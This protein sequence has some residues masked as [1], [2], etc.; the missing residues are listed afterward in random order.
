V[1]EL[2]LGTGEA[3]DVLAAV[4]ARVGLD[5]GVDLLLIKGASL[6]AHGLREDRGRGDV[7]VLVRPKHVGP[8]RRVLTTLGWSAFNEPSVY[9]LIVPPHA[10]TFVHPRWH[11]EID[12][13]TF[14][15]GCYADPTTCFEHL[16]AERTTIQLAHQPVECTGPAGSALI[17]GLTLMRTPTRPRMT[18]ESSQWRAAVSAWP[19]PERM[20]L[21]RLAADCQSADALAPLFDAAGVPPVGRGANTTANWTDWNDRV[22]QE[23]RR[24]YVWATSI[25]RAPL[26][27][28]PRLA[29]RALTFDPEAFA[30]GM[31][32]PTGWARARQVGRRINLIRSTISRFR[33][34]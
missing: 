27:E 16:W 34:D 22:G 4:V 26:R 2:A 8:L 17:G 12:V 31:P 7:D 19:E 15:P 5:A 3:R 28:K 6:T 24:G 30:R 20:A 10:I 13:H 18:T 21:A 9:P 14:V 32:Q 25:R 1:I 23:T 11:T 29:V 33:R